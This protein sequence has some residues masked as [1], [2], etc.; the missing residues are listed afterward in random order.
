MNVNEINIKLSRGGERMNE[1][2]DFNITIISVGMG[3]CM[4]PIEAMR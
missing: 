2:E 1:S 3:D 4:C